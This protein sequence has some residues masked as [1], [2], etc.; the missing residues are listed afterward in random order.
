[1]EK[2]L[3]ILKSEYQLDDVQ[4]RLLQLNC[5]IIK[6]LG[7][8]R[9]L[10]KIEKDQRN[11]RDYMTEL[12][13]VGQLYRELG[14]SVA[15]FEMVYEEPNR[16]GAPDL[17]IIVDGVQYWI[18]IKHLNEMNMEQINRR[19][20]SEIHEVLALVP[21]GLNYDLHHSA[22]LDFEDVASIDEVFSRIVEITEGQ[23]IRVDL[24]TNRHMTFVFYKTDQEI[25]KHLTPVYTMGGVRMTSDERREQLTN[26]AYTAIR[27][28]NWRADEEN[29]NLIAVEANHDVDPID[30]GNVFYGDEDNSRAIGM[31]R[32]IVR[33]TNGLMD[34]EEFQAK[35]SGYILL[36]NIRNEAITEYKKYLF[37]AKGKQLK[38]LCKAF[39][40][41]KVYNDRSWIE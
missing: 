28:I 19:I 27:S 18:Q 6:R 9:I 2:I 4:T 24:P 1:M 11:R 36:K 38:Q 31:E 5:D 33:E 25:L 30:I 35:L 39:S 3:K 12:N 34:E 14:D 20:I 23:T 29:V 37:L 13:L 40:F 26:S 10:E 8:E 41:D 21:I 15:E 7:F 22:Y 16:M 32:E 17:K